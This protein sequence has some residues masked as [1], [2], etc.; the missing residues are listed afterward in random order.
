MSQIIRTTY[1]GQVYNPVE[2]EETVNKSIATAD[3]LKEQFGFD[4][5][6]FSGMSGAAMAYILAHWMDMPLLCVRRK[7]DG[8]HRRSLLP[9]QLL[10]GNF[11][12]RKYLIVDDFIDT[13]STVNYIIESIAREIPTAKCVSMLMYAG[14]GTVPYNYKHTT[15]TEP[16]K[17]VSSKPTI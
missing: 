15:W 11:G 1:M 5:I 3:K 16:V 6:A 10:E 4:T 13:G 12:V 17:V 2:F 14:S 9:N 7:E 8:S